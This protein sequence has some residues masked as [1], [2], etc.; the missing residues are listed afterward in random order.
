MRCKKG[1]ELA[2]LSVLVLVVSCSLQAG[3]RHKTVGP[4]PDRKID[5]SKVTLYVSPDGSDAND[6]KTPATALATLQKGTDMAGPG[7]TVLAMKGV[8]TKPFH[9]Q[10]SGR[11]D[12]WITFLAE[13]G[14]EIRGSE[15]RKDWK[16]VPGKAA[17][18][19]VKRPR[20]Y[21]NHQKSSTPLQIR[22]EQ[23]FA[24]D[25]ILSQVSEYAMLKERGTFYVDD[26]KERIYICLVGGKD[27]NREK[28]EV[29]KN[30]YAIAVGAKPGQNFWRDEKSEKANRAAYIRIDGFRI[31]HVSNFTRMAAIQIRGVCHD[32]IVENCDVQWVNYSGIVANGI[33]IYSPEMKRWIH[34]RCKDITIRHCIVS[35]I[36]AQA[37]SGS[38]NDDFLIEYNLMDNNNYKGVSP[39]AEGGGVKT[40]FGGNRIVIRGNVLRNNDNHGIWFDYGSEDCVFENN[41]IYN[42]VAGGILNE[43]TPRPKQ[44]YPP[45][46]K[47]GY[48]KTTVA[49]IRKIT[50][51][52][53]TIRNNISIATRTPGGVGISIGHGY[54]TTA[55]NNITYN[56]DGC[57]MSLG[58]NPLRKNTAGSSR[59]RTHSNISYM[60][61]VS[62]TQISEGF[63][64]AGRT[65]DLLQSNNLYIAPRSG[66][67]FRIDKKNATLEEWTKLNKG[68]KNFCSD[69]NIFRDPARWD[70][71]ITDPAMAKKIDFDVNAMRLDWS[72]YFIAKDVVVTKRARRNY[73]PVDLSKVFNRALV[74]GVSGDGKGGWTD[75]GNNDMRNLPTGEQTINGVKFL[76]GTKEKGA[77]MLANKRVKADSVSE[78]VRV[79]VGGKFDEMCFFYAG[80]WVGDSY[81]DANGKRVKIKNP[82]AANFVVKYKGGKTVLVPIVVNKHILDWWAAPTWQQNA[83]MNDNGVYTAWQGANGLTG[84]VTAYYYLWANPFPDTKITSITMTKKGVNV[85][86]AFFLLGLTGANRPKGGSARKLYYDFDGQIDAIASDGSEIIA[87]GVNRAAFDQGKFADGIKGHA[88]I[89]KKPFWIPTPDDFPLKGRGT[90]SLWLKADKWNT[91]KRLAEMK[92]LGYRTVMTPFEGQGAKSA[93][94]PWVI[95]FQADP[96]TYDKLYLKVST[97]GHPSNIDITKRLIPEKWFNLTI[98][99]K[100]SKKKGFSDRRFYFNGK[101]IQDKP[102]QSKMNLIGKHIYIGCPKNGG[103]PWRGAMDE[104]IITNKHSTKADVT[105]YLAGFKK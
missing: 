74:D 55:Y 102:I 56:N 80:A 43:V 37:I 3:Y 60:D 44:L 10:K 92:R 100:P 73:T 13:P 75:H 67:F 46:G 15:V 57:G 8:H 34:S 11:P 42:S 25:K 41:L 77:V 39:W 20:L 95:S 30:T 93:Y 6:G 33:D 78:E 101:L 5:Y 87:Q 19:Y 79:P 86:C 35:N 22:N 103:Q 88:Y 54:G 23:V 47:K 45:S 64:K 105:R 36:G 89:P 2:L 68:K 32:I 58:G 94:S 63:D 71:T 50:G 84:Q 17:I 70:F 69:K 104:L 7:D 48:V 81:K 16:K 26:A 66:V 21:S 82:T 49:V 83:A 14:A 9:I 24:N 90:I 91:P 27:A 62:A 1:L 61:F 72:E 51:T 96:K 59:Y 12:A 31:R 40:G 85:N 53:T 52:G 18:Y 76:L 38:N 28:V 97:S 4:L 65:F 99:W 98:T 29:T